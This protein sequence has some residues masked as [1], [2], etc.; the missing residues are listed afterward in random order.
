MLYKSRLFLMSASLIASLSQALPLKTINEDFTQSYRCEEMSSESGTQVQLC[1][2]TTTQEIE[3][4]MKIVKHQEDKQVITKSGCKIIENIENID[5][6]TLVKTDGM[7]SWKKIIDCVE[8]QDDSDAE[9]IPF[10]A[11]HNPDISVR[12]TL[13]TPENSF[14][15]DG[16]AHHPLSFIPHYLHINKLIDLESHCYALDPSNSCQVTLTSSIPE[17]FIKLKKLPA[18]S[19]VHTDI[20]YSAASRSIQ[21]ALQ[22]YLDTLSH[23]K[24]YTYGI[25]LN[26]LFQPEQVV[27]FI[28][29][30]HPGVYLGA[31]H[32]PMGDTNMIT[33]YFYQDA[34]YNYVDS[35]GNTP[36]VLGDSMQREKWYE[37]SHA[38]SADIP[39]TAVSFTTSLQEH[40]FYENAAASSRILYTRVTVNSQRL[41]AATQEI[42]SKLKQEEF[43][44]L[45]ENLYGLRATPMGHDLDEMHSLEIISRK[46]MEPKTSNCFRAAI[47]DI[48]SIEAK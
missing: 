6:L 20:L 36:G 27:T 8:A 21:T 11:S 33:K 15:T 46:A 47:N 3:L 42:V 37:K 39:A 22:T 41:Q 26:A 30:S 10:S 23:Y 19:V 24:K 28:T 44:C 32:Y 7:M 34:A 14:V 1:S 31:T 48:F 43:S 25:Y 4:R 13:I 18:Q 40:F 38:G 2:T 29:G 35:A 45:A 9:Y 5:T 17:I 16:H 12:R